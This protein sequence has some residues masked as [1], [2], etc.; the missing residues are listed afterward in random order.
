MNAGQTTTTPGPAPGTGARAA[1]RP[2]AMTLVVLADPHP[3]SRSAL[4]QLLRWADDVDVVASVATASAAAE[5][6]GRG[7]VHVLAIDRLLLDAALALRARAADIGWVVLGTGDHPGY[8]GEALAGGAR[9][10]VVKD[11][12]DEDLVALLLD[13]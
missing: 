6:L 2:H 7:A 8:R 10:Y 13:R 5:A 11:R 3:A 12:A 1:A 9:G 4:E